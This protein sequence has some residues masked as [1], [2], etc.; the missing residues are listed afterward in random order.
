MDRLERRDHRARRRR[1][2]RLPLV[3]TRASGRGAGR[4]RYHPC[5]RHAGC[6]P[7]CL[8]LR[9]RPAPRDGFIKNHR[10]G[11]RSGRR[12][13]Q[14]RRARSGAGASGRLH[15]EGRIC[16]GRGAGRGG[17]AL[18][19]RERGA[20]RSGASQRAA[21]G[22]VAEGKDRVAV[23]ARRREGRS[24]FARGAHRGAE[25]TDPRRR[26]ADRAAEDGS[27]QLRHSR[28]V[29]RRRDLEGRAS[30]RSST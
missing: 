9:G 10:Q 1:I 24:G 29:Q 22:G 8:R 17:A 21:R 11:G 23:T 2:R 20:A 7:Q 6:R 12:G 5:S 28:A 18:A 26:A 19:A 4:H 30:A 14:E 16:A 3:D 27:R 15:A 25:R 13:G